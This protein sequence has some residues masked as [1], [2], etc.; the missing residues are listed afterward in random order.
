MG[1]LA[2]VD[3]G[4]TTFSEQLLYKT[5]TIRSIG[6]VDHADAFMDS[7]PLEKQRGITIFN[8]QA[9]VRLG[10]HT[11]QLLD[12]PG[13]ADFGGE[14]ERA[15]SVLD[16]A[17][18]VISCAEGIQSHTR[19]VWRLLEKYGVPVVIFMNKTDR[20]GADPEGILEQL[21]KD[22][23]GDMLDL[24]AWKS[25]AEDCAEDIASRDEELISRYLDTG[26]DA[27]I[28]NG[29]VSRMFFER[30]IFPVMSGSALRS[31]GIDE[32]LS[33]LNV[34][35]DV[36]SEE[37]E[38][39]DAPFTAKVYKV[40]ADGRF[41][42]TVYMKV[43]SGKAVPRAPINGTYDRITSLFSPQGEHLMP[44]NEAPRGM[45]CAAVGLSASAGD[46]VGSED[47]ASAGVLR[48]MLVTSARL[49]DG[50]SSARFMEI[51]RIL[52][53][54]DPLLDVSWQ[55]RT[56]SVNVRVMGNIQIETLKAVLKERFGL[57]VGFEKCRV[58]Y[59]ETV[60]GECEGVGHY[61]PLRH[62]AEVRLLI[63]SAPRGSGISFESRCHV[64]FL[65]LHW[66]TLIKDIL[67][68]RRHK[69]VLTGAELT[70]VKLILLNGRMHLKH[71]EGGDFYEAAGRA[72]RNA[73]MRGKSVLLE[74]VCRFEA[75]GPTQ[76][77]DALMR[78]FLRVKA[79]LDTSERSADRAVFAGTATVTHII[80][81]AEL[82]PMLTHGHGG[83]SWESTGYTECLNA[84]EVI[85][86]EAY[87]PL[88]DTEN[89]PHSVFCAKGAGFT[90]NWDHVEEY[91]HTSGEAHY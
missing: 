21:R 46:T 85:A 24:R 60:E 37:K 1:M 42:R 45:L 90:V 15:V 22:M 50:I 57:D 88:A 52:E 83:I 55:Q 56:G 86:A 62:Y 14:M 71:T 34:I 70:D 58:C 10:R 28:W 51:M 79:V 38:K 54:E 67:L 64:D 49:P 36:R 74:P 39:P 84:D 80:E 17:V 61:E 69:G 20:A 7:H 66:Q 40:R 4:K 47:G 32:F 16:M 87:D 41:G 48:P 31:E 53:D 76:S 19:T 27:D 43:L 44:L 73:L 9:S 33:L 11:V 2:H 13:H 35:L 68:K 91:A 25:S 59:A 63:Q 12:T 8:Q 89:P 75:E 18:L 77:Y 29:A 72:V 78:E 82:M 65:P 30:K 23:S 26:Y 6:R 3:A 5:N 81:I